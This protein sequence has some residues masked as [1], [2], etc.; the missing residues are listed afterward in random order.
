[1]PTQAQLAVRLATRQAAEPKYQ[2]KPKGSGRHTGAS[3]GPGPKGDSAWCQAATLEPCLQ[4]LSHGQVSA[5]LELLQELSMQHG[6]PDRDVG[7][8]ILLVR[9]PSNR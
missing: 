6:P 8:T 1:M 3:P 4:L 5:A 2:G 7:D 9:P